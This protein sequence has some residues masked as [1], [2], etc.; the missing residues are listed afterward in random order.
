MPGL[1]CVGWAK[2]GPSGTIG[3]N[4]PDGF[5]VVDLIA[6]D[7]LGTQR[8]D[9]REGLE[10]LLGKRGVDVVSF[11]DWQNIDRAEIARA[12]EGSPREKFVALHDMIAARETQ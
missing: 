7:V 6:E 4:R 12:R 5:A 11:S 2:R 3:T 10:A 1:Y 8:K 9:G